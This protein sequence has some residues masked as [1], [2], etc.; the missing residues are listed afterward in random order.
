M[1]P[2]VSITD[3]KAVTTSLKIAEVFEKQH[4]SV[5]RSI[6][7]LEIPQ[8]VS[9]HN[10]ALTSFQVPQPN[11]GT[12]NVKA[13]LITRDGFTLLAMGFTGKKAMQFKLAYIEAFNQ[14]EAELK[15][16]SSTSDPYDNDL[17]QSTIRMLNALNVRIANSENV[18][19]HILKYAW[20]MANCTRTRSFAQ[21]QS[22]D[23]LDDIRQVFSVFAPGTRIPKNEVYKA[24]CDSTAHP[25]SP[26]AFWPNAKKAVNLRESS[27][28]GNRYVTI[29]L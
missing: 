7:S 19:A 25:V 3:G 24:Y 6:E 4:K 1:S 8:E 23:E 21:F 18:P 20:N 11:G 13:Y 2:L 9:K 29:I 15:K 26:R 10:F 14:M 17:L 16:T 12:R 27:S 28:C 22:D 5:I